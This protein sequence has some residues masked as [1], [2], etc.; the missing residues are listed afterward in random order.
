MRV[1]LFGPPGAGKGTQA[2]LIATRYSIPH[3]STGDIFRTNIKNET[4]LGLKVKEYMDNGLLVPDELTIDIVK[5]RIKND[6]CK[7]GF[8][9]DGFPRTINQ[10][11]ALEL[12]LEENGQRLNYAL[13]IKVP[14][15]SILDR[16]TGRRVCSVCGASYHIKYNPPKVEGKCDLCK[17]EISQRED[18]SEET[19]TARL[20]IYDKQTEPLAAYYKSK[21]I[22]ESVDGTKDINVVFESIR[23][24]LGEIK[25]DNY[26][27]W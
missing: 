5:D 15:G 22:L 24:I 12:F 23:D 21:D 17:N 13:L 20:D 3:I 18:D 4:S 9:L 8:L 6:D 26:K 1:I 10:A 25:N 2:K 14:R 19:I 27:K 11:L 16:M 7:V